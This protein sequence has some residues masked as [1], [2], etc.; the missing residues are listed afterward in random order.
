MGYEVKVGKD[1]TVRPYDRPHGRKL[2]RNLG[3]DYAL[4]NI[5]K[6][7]LAQRRPQRVETPEPRRCRL[8]GDLKQARKVTGFRALYFHYCYLLGVFPKKQNR[9][10][11][12]VPH[13]LR[14]DLIRAQELTD[15]ARLL[16]RHRIDTLE[17]LNAYQSEVKS[18]LASLTEQR[19]RLYR[20]LRTKAALADPARQEQIRAEIAA[21]SG[22]LKD[23]R[24]EVKLCEDIAARS[25]SL[26]EKI[27]AAREEQQAG[28]TEKTR[29]EQGRRKRLE[30]R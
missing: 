15:E 22:Q 30:R 25:L 18:Q 13:A 6:R 29:Q 4:E 3:E 27:R 7:I 24:R 2:A 21:L 28:K 14:E 17:Q 16:S 1:I 5:R 10:R 26:K 8:L 20:K 19:K 23:L 11:G 9:Q 12:H